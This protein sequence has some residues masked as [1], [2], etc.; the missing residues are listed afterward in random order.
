MLKISLTWTF[1]VV[2]FVSPFGQIRADDQSEHG[3]GN[4]W[5]PLGHAEKVQLPEV[6]YSESAQQFTHSS[7]E[8]T[9]ML[10]GADDQMIATVEGLL[11]DMDAAATP[12]YIT[13]PCL[14]H[15]KI[16]LEAL[17]NR[18]MWALGSK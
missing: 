13:E 15:T 4:P 17:V 2:I 10:A 14:N 3:E 7:N 18:E 11:G 9:W 12:Y 1:L 16:F 6:K 8:L 5:R